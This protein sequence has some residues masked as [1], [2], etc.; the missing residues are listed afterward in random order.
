MN[1]TLNLFRIIPQQRYLN[2]WLSWATIGRQGSA[3][4]DKASKGLEITFSLTSLLFVEFQTCIKCAS[5]RSRNP[6][7][8]FLLILLA[9]PVYFLTPF[10]LWLFLSCF[11]FLVLFSSFLFFLW[12]FP[13]LFHAWFLYLCCQYATCIPITG[14]CEFLFCWRHWYNH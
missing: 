10:L 2:I 3:R 14:A 11:V 13:F 4:L 5:W 7:S 9:S 8:T 1:G 6:H 12:C